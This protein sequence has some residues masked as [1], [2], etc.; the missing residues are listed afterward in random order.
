MPNYYDSLIELMAKDVRRK[1]HTILFVDD[2]PIALKIL[3]HLFQRNFNVLTADCGE[4]AIEILKLTKGIA[5]VCS[6][7]KMPG[8]VGNELL[9]YVKQNYAEATRILMTAYSDLDSVISSINDAGVYRYVQK[10]WNQEDFEG[11]IDRAVAIS[12]LNQ[13]LEK[14]LHEEEK[15]HAQN[16]SNTS[17]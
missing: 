7:Q 6:D 4:Q 9:E 1:N 5:V 2:E 15:N 3:K 10:P 17:N 8:I 14:A 11:I 13:R 12:I 16:S